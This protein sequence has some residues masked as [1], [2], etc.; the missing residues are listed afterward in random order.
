MMG[1]VGSGTPGQRR[2]DSGRTAIPLFRYL[3][4]RNGHDFCSHD[5]LNLTSVSLIEHRHLHQFRAD[6]FDA[7]VPFPEWIGRTAS[8]WQ[9][10]RDDI[11]FVNL[12]QCFSP[13]M[14]FVGLLLE[15]CYY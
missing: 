2:I 4:F 12:P 15:V 5:K 9:Q 7:P 13:D 3:T 6:P 1:G 8:W 14:R 11:S 10:I